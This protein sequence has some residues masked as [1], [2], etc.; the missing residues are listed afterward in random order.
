MDLHVRG[1]S[2]LVTG[3]SRGLGYA[4]AAA[5]VEDGAR[6][7]I[8][9]RHPEALA[10][11]TATLGADSAWFA[12]DN[13]DDTAAEK[14]V[15]AAV[16]HGGTGK[17]DGMLISVG[18][19]SP[20]TALDTSDTSWRSAFESLFVGALRF[21]RAAVPVMDAGSSI[22]FV[23]SSSVRN[24]IPGLAASNAI[25]PALAMTAKTLSD[26]LGPRGIRVVGFVPGQILT[27]RTLELS[28][29]HPPSNAGSAIPL[30]RLGDPAE[31][32]RVVAFVLSPAASYVT[33]CVI[34]IDGGLMRSL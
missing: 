10:S 3:A 17:L 14:A 6:V 23:L 5:L 31:F 8:S 30:G 9:A 27:E 24:P 13:A 2:Y 12:A 22:G 28:A 20:S 29:L 25:R 33:G 19:P 34:P 7:T 32:G 15:A 11:A 4:V 21:V 16:T 1:R 18:G 26:E